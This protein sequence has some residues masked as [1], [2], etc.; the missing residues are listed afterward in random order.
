MITGAGG[1]LSGGKTAF[2]VREIIV[3]AEVSGKK[4]ISNIKLQNVEYQHMPNEMFVEIIQ[5]A[6]N[7]SELLRK[8][9]FKKILFLDEITHLL[10]ARKSSSNL[11]VLITNFFMYIGKLDC[12]VYFTYQVL[13]SQ[14]DTRVR[15]VCNVNAECIRLDSYGRPIIFRDRILDE[16]VYIL[17]IKIMDLGPLL[18][19]KVRAEVFDPLP[20][21]KYYDTREMVSLD[22]EKYLSKR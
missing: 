14:V 18:G 19:K 21:V 1:K 9:F 11:N 2:C 12:D 10:D 22:R 5:N 8:T 13:D 15:D 17:V 20:Y 3:N 4:V 16:Q 7:D 6:V